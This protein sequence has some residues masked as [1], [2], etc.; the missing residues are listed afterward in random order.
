LRFSSPKAQLY[1]FIVLREFLLFSD[2]RGL[3][4]VVFAAGLRENYV[5]RG[6]RFAGAG[7]HWQ[8]AALLF[9]EVVVSS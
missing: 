5:L 6:G 8:V 2:V 4:V 7:K 3:N 9:V 1:L